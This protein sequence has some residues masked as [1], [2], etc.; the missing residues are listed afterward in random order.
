MAHIHY[1]DVNNSSASQGNPLILRNL[2]LYYGIFNIQLSV[3]I[4]SQINPVL[5]FI[6]LLKLYLNIIFQSTP[7]PSEWAHSFSIP[8][9][10]IC[11]FLFY[12]LK[13]HKPQP[14]NPPSIVF[15]I[16]RNVLIVKLGSPSP[17]FFL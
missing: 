2:N 14:I 12:T 7:L 11:A 8:Q 5:S 1:L 4:L 6:L 10:V 9:N 13:F 15:H 17:M 3:A 16:Q